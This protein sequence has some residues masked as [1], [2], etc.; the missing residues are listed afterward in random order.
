[1]EKQKRIFGFLF[2]NMRPTI[3]GTYT[4]I[5]ETFLDKYGSWL[6]ILEAENYINS[7]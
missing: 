2:L 6:G 7:K 5:N 4:N 3:V 1:M